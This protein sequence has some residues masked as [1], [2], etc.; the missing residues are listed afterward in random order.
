MKTYISASIFAVSTL[1]FISCDPD[2]Q[3]MPDGIILPLKM[4]EDGYKRELLYE[5]PGKLI[6]VRSTSTMADE[7]FIQTIQKMEYN[8][9]G[10]LMRTIIDGNWQME[11]T[12]EGSRIIRTDESRNSQPHQVHIFQYNMSGR[13]VDMITYRQESTGLVPSNKINNVYDLEGN[14]M[15]SVSYVY[16]QGEYWLNTT[17]TYSDY[18]DMLSSDHMF[19]AHALNPMVKF[20]MNNP[21]KMEVKNLNGMITSTEQYTYQYN[22]QNFPVLRYTTVTFPHNGNTGIYKTEF[23]Y[24]VK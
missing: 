11:Y 18:D 13:M 2:T 8:E 10:R 23:F 15:E 5:Q 17:F 24:D 1:F 4:E 20:H 19:S 14:L 3:T 21:G 16:D 6:T 9:H 7:T 12:Y 22:I